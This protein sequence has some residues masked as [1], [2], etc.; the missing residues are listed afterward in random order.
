MTV[1]LFRVELASASA[2]LGRAGSSVSGAGRDLVAQELTAADGGFA[3]DELASG[4]YAVRVRYPESLA[5]TWDS[6]GQF[7]AE[8]QVVVTD[9]GTAQA[10]VG[11]AGDARA[12]LRVQTPS[13]DPITGTVL[14]WWAGP[15]GEFG[16]DDDVRVPVE[17]VDGRVQAGGLPPGQYRV[18]G[19]DGSSASPPLDLSEDGRPT[20]VTVGD[21]PQTPHLAVTGWA[22]AALL[23]PAV[24]LIVGGLLLTR[25]ARRREG[26][27]RG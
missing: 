22:G 25:A 2:A 18:V 13:G 5:V 6:E 11:L 1:E 12:D 19:P 4:A 10:E 16:T 26:P 17:A 8:A 15:D 27:Q 24:S 20:T 21:D 3:F 23:V 9:S 14:L 7:D